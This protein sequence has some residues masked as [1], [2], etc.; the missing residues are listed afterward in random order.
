MQDDWMKILTLT[1]QVVAKE[2][3]T[4]HEINNKLKYIMNSVDIT[5]S[6]S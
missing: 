3:E 2:L 1:L 4:I 6:H 5:Y